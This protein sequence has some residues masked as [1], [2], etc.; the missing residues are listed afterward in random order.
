MTWERPVPPP[1]DATVAGPGTDTDAGIESETEEP[2]NKTPFTLPALPGRLAAALTGLVAGVFGAMLTYL[3]LQGCNAVSG[4][5][6]CGGTGVLLLVIILVLMTLLGGAILKAG[7]VTDAQSTSLLA[8]GVLCVIVLVTLDAG[9][10]LA[11]DVPGRADPRRRR[12][13]ALALGHHHVHRADPRGRAPTTTYAELRLS[14][15]V[16]TTFIEPTPE[17][18]PDHDVR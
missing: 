8:V 4:T 18:G 11:V 2:A 12:L 9:T 10:V 16:T 15:W 5:Q 17:D 13:R 1:A 6:S 7:Q 3:S 14:H